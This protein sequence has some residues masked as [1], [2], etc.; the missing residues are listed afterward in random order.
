MFKDSKTKKYD[1]HAIRTLMASK[2]GSVYKWCKAHGWA[3][4]TLSMWE[5][6]RVPQIATMKKLANDLYGDKKNWQAI[7]QFF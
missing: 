6:G 1:L 4:N 2:S 5:A 7:A 3:S